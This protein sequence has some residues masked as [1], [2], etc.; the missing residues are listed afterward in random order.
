MVCSWKACGTFDPLMNPYVD[1]SLL[2]E[3]LGDRTKD[4]KSRREGDLMFEDE[5][6]TSA[7]Q[8]AARSYNSLPPFVGTAHWTRLSA[9]SDMF[10]DAA[11]ATAMERRA[12]K[13]A[14]ERVAFTAGGIQTD[15]DGAIIDSLTKEAARLRDKFT[16]EA[17]AFKANQN[18]NAAFR[19]VG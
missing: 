5:E 9:N 17:A 2:R 19:R 13:L 11:A 7:L 6:L 10:L 4:V 8:A 18:W 16:R 12:R 15:P 3:H 1:I 14:S